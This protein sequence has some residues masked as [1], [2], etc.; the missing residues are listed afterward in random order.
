M[1][2]FEPSGDREHSGWQTIAGLEDI[3]SIE[4]MYE[5]AL[6]QIG[7]GLSFENSYLGEIV[8]VKVIDIRK[9]VFVLDNG[10]GIG[11]FRANPKWQTGPPK[12]EETPKDP[13]LNWESPP[14]KAGDQPHF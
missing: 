10:V 4:D 11:D 5:D 14:F 13:P 8:G 7:F 12:R 3:L 1:P 2:E 9:I 6:G